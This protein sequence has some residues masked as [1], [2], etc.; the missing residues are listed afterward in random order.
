MQGTR[1]TGHLGGETEFRRGA[2]GI[3]SRSKFLDLPQMGLERQTFAVRIAFLAATAILILAGAS[4]N[5]SGRQ[6]GAAFLAV[7]AGLFAIAAGALNETWKFSAPAGLAAVIAT[8][9]AASWDFTDT[10]LPLEVGGL[11]LLAIGGFVGRN[12]YHKFTPPPPPPPDANE[13]QG[14]PPGGEDP[15]VVA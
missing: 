7:I 10:Q 11:L 13:G 8:L 3:S 6:G 2:D 1:G 12:A 15:V 5:V 4:M 9:G 14:G